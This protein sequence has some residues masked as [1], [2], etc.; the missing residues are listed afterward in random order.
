MDGIKTTGTLTD[1]LRSTRP[2]EIDRYVEEHSGE[3]V[4]NDRP[5]AA[6][7]RG[8]L[9]EKGIRQQDVFLAADISEG[10]GY[11][12]LSEEKHTKQRD[13]ILRLCLAGHFSLTEV[14]RALRIYGMSPLYPRA[15]RD[16]AL[17]IAF[18]TGIWAIPEVNELLEAHGFSALASTSSAE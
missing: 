15:P 4:E 8:T 12:L 5:F 9:R 13:I 17:I 18:N 10:Y 2:E 1:I 14:Q 7:M 11:K 6:Y 3:F 16:A